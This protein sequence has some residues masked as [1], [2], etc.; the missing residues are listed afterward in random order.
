MKKYHRWKQCEYG[1]QCKKCGVSQRKRA[2]I[3]ACPPTRFEIMTMDVIHCS[4]FSQ[5]LNF[6]G[7]HFPLSGVSKGNI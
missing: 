4:D 2:H 1:V 3:T 7:L 5:P 6:D